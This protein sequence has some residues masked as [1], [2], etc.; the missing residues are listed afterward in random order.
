MLQVLWLNNYP[1]PGSSLFFCWAFIV[2]T[3]TTINQPQRFRHCI[4]MKN[5]FI[6][7]SLRHFY[8]KFYYF[9]FAVSCHALDIHKWHLCASKCWRDA[10]NLLRA[11]KCAKRYEHC[12]I[13][14]TELLLCKN[15]I[16][17]HGKVDRFAC[18][19]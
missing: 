4:Y 10:H 12:T 14:D 6:V 1:T 18:S 8:F 11:V 9:I 19:K 2:S 3:L 13:F 17:V 16:S 7:N 5:I 15:I